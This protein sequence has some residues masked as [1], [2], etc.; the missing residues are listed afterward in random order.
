MSGV[1]DS[2]LR[3]AM[4]KGETA[5]RFGHLPFFKGRHDALPRDTKHI[6]YPALFRRLSGGRKFVRKKARQ[7]IDNIA[8]PDYNVL[9]CI[10]EIQPR[11]N[12]GP[13]GRFPIRFLPPGGALS[14][15]RERSALHQGGCANVV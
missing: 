3:E 4:T 15:G 10:A 6:L 1:S 12:K 2:S 9:Y 13:W 5:R 14:G 8:E 11:W 7:K